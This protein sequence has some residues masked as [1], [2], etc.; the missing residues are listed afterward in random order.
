MYFGLGPQMD[1]ILL[2]KKI[3]YFFWTIFTG[4]VL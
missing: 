3:I 1:R 2:K 4:T